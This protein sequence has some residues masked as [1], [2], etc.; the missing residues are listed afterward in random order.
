MNSLRSSILRN[1]VST[2][3]GRQ[4]GFVEKFFK[5]LDKCN[6]STQINAAL[7]FMNICYTAAYLC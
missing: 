3:A 2:E 4:Q 6:F 5:I 1:T 7:R